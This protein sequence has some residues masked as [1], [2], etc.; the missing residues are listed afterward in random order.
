MAEGTGVTKEERERRVAL[1]ERTI[2]D[3]GW[4]RTVERALAAHLGV[5]TRTIRRYKDDVEA[6]VRKEGDRDRRAIRASLL[7][8]LRGYQQA[9]KDA[10]RFGPLASM[11]GIEARMLGVLDR[12]DDPVDD[13]LEALTKEDLLREIATDLSAEDIRE[14]LRLRGGA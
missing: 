14:L 7:V 8:R 13:G 5:T 3:K 6:A 1:V 11:I 2:H 9:A 10:N 12:Q 4:S